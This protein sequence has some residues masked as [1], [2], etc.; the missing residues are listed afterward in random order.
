MEKDQRRQRILH[1]ELEKAVHFDDIIDN[2]AAGEMK[3]IQKKL[4]KEN[5]KVSKGT[6]VK[7]K[8]YIETI[9]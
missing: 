3:S 8:N 4:Q 9:L 7:A 5:N 6:K 1:D 2:S